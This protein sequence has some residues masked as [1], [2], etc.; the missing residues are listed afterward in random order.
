M[1]PTTARVIGKAYNRGIASHS[2]AALD[3]R[4]ARNFRRAGMVSIRRS[5]GFIA[6]LIDPVL[7][8]FTLAYSTLQREGYN[9]SFALY[10]GEK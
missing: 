10:T 4:R 1:V 6:V 3:C 5:A 7:N 8:L 9:R 2:T